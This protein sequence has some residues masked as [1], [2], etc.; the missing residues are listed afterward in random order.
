[1]HGN[2][3]G[4]GGCSGEGECT[5]ELWNA[6]LLLFRCV[7][8]LQTGGGKRVSILLLIEFA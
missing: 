5:A 1:M 8:R 2:S 6:L 4:S 7:H 3:E